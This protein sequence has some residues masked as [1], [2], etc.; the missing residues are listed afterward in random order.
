M[1]SPKPV[2]AK[3]NFGEAIVLYPSTRANGTTGSSPH[4]PGVIGASDYAAPE[5]PPGAHKFLI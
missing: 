1:L 3:T 4:V 2:S 5:Q